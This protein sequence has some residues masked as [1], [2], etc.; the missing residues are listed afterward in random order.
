MLSACDKKHNR[1]LKA[2][3]FLLLAGL[4]L[5]FSCAT[6][7]SAEEVTTDSRSPRLAH[8]IDQLITQARQ[9]QQVQAAPRST[10]A[11]FMRRVYLDLTGKIPPVAEV[12]QFLAD[13][14][15]DKRERLIDRLL[16]SP[17]FVVHFTSLWRNILIPEAGTDP[18]A[19]Q[20][21]PE[22]EAWLRSQLQ[23]DISY[24][25]LVRA[26]VGGPFDETT[27]TTGQTAAAEPTARAFYLVKQL[28][29]ESLAASTSRAFL[30]VRIE[31]AQC[32]DHPFDTWKQD[33]FWQ[34][35]AFF[36]NIDQP[37]PNTFV[38]PA[39]LRE[40]TGKPEIKIPDT[41]RLVEATYLNGKQ[42]DWKETPSSPRQRLSEWITSAQNP[43]F[44]KATANRVWSLF[45]G[46]G[47]VDPVDDFSSTNPASHPELLEE[48]ARAFQKHDYDL[49]YLIREITN[50]ETYQLTS[51]QT[52][53]SQSRVEWYGK[54][55]TRGLTAEQIF[56]NLVQATGFFRQTGETDPQLIAPGMNSPQAEIQ[57]LFKT[58]SENQLEPRATILQALVLMNGTFM[59]NATSLEQSDVFTAI[60]D[61]PGQS[62][63]QKIEAFYLSTLSRP[64]TDTELNKLKTYIDSSEVKTEAYANLFWALL[65]SSEFLLN[66]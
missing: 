46:R 14:A 48:M 49:K 34:F 30:G 44:A 43:Y 29:P 40:V 53:P 26:I 21:V 50:S 11:E 37:Q 28:K 16:A 7:F 19:R 47:I 55:P 61:F 38:T 35:A 65:N 25:A 66:H 20:Q 52:D 31:C 27:R 32:H 63:E 9:Q 51:R 41:N 64:P 18:L 4:I 59:T 1:G 58:E 17:G 22:F 23:Q 45:F 13:S 3:N 39:N 15:P 36:A 2:D 56:A 8:Q 6:A 57:D 10:D 54:M 24:D 62:V 5:M 12:R 33:Q 60:V 42:P